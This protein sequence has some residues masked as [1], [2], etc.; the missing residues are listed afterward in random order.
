ML[1]YQKVMKNKKIGKHFIYR[2]DNY[3]RLTM[4]THLL[5]LD[6]IGFFPQTL[7]DLCGEKILSVEFF[8]N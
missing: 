5:F 8:F 1:L 7:C 4:D 3:S 6:I 2:L